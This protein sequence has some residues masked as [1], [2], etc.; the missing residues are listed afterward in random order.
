MV[1]TIASRTRRLIRKALQISI[2]IE[3]H[4]RTD[5]KDYS[6]FAWG[7]NVTTHVDRQTDGRTD[8]QTELRAHNQHYSG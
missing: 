3:R 5:R 2:H 4:R 1:G 8:K 7:L 6:L